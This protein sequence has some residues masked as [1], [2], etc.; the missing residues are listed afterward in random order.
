MN[1]LTGIII[2]QEIWTTSPVMIAEKRSTMPVA[3][4]DQY[5][6]NSRR[7][8]KPIESLKK[9][10]GLIRIQQMNQEEKIL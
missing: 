7:T 4:T 5:K 1:Y 10:L 8:L 3:E 9:I 6:P 2:Q